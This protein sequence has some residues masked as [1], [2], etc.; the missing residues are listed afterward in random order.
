MMLM[1]TYSTETI[2]G[3]LPSNRYGTLEAIRWRFGD[4]V[5]IA[6]AAPI[7][8]HLKDLCPYWAGFARTG[9]KP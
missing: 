5:N 4:K 3:E 9:F 1:H 2:E 7:E 6:D 8:V